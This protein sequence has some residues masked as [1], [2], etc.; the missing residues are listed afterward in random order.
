VKTEFVLKSAAQNKAMDLSRAENPIFTGRAV[1]A[2]ASDP[3]VMEKS[4]RV[5]VVAELAKEYG[6]RDDA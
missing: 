1:V 6:F 3:K 5:L 4:G 2:L